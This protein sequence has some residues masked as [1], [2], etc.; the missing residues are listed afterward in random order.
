MEELCR[1]FS[2]RLREVI[3]NWC[4]P[5][6]PVKDFAKA[7][8]IHEN[9]IY[10]YMNGQYLPSAMNLCRIC[11]FLSI[12]ADWLLGLSDVKERKNYSPHIE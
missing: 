6:R 7:L 12:S 3:W 10:T 1:I 9:T 2:E 11:D 8:G 4:G 5:T